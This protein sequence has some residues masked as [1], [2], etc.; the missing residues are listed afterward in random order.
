MSDHP[1]S[2]DPAGTPLE[3]M[4]AD[5]EFARQS[6]LS[7][8]DHLDAHAQSGESCPECDAKPYK[9]D[10]AHEREWVAKYDR[11]IERLRGAVRS[12]RRRNLAAM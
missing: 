2:S 9:L 6:H 7:W 11:I 4:L 5:L 8:A 1:A 12:T 3:A 10:A